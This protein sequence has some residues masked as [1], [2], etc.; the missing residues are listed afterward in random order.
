MLTEAADNGQIDA[1]LALFNVY[2]Q[3]EQAVGLDRNPA[4]ANRYIDRI[5]QHIERHGIEGLN[6]Q[7]L[8][9][10]GYA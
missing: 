5:N 3:G 2:M 6:P 1:S 7:Y 4:M 8:Y 9:N 10:F